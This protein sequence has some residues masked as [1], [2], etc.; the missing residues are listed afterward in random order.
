MLNK[1]KQKITESLQKARERGQLTAQEVYNIVHE[2]VIN[3]SQSL[4]KGTKD[5]HEIT[6]EAVTSTVQSLQNAGEASRDNI[7]AGLHGAIDAVKQ[8]ESQMLDSADKELAQ[9]RARLMKEEKILAQKLREA[10]EGAE[11]ATSD[12]SGEVK[13]DM[14][15]VAADA[16]LKSAELLGL[17][18]ETVKAAVKQAIEA[19]TKV[20]ETVADVTRDATTKGLAG[21]RFSAERTRRISESVLSAAV[22]AAEELGSHVKE[23]SSATAKGVREGLIHMVEDTHHTLNVAEGRFKEFAIEDLEQTKQDELES[24]N[25]K[26]IGYKRQEGE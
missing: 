13:A 20:E 12:F 24:K 16:K 19:G 26:R 15:S 17:T 5:L 7:A 11:K 6:Y 3:T 22:D 18:R 14:E 9:A 1:M 23:V 2:S 8:V 21:A 25:R 10:I 4:K